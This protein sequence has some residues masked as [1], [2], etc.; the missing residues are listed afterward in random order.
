MF[1]I[2]WQFINNAADKYNSLPGGAKESGK[3]AD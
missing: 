1:L 3:H 2:T